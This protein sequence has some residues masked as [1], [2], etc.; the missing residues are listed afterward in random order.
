MSGGSAVSRP[1]RK[2]IRTLYESQFLFRK[3][4]SLF[5]KQINGVSDGLEFCQLLTQTLFEFLSFSVD[6]FAI[7]GGQSPKP[8]G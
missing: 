2:L 8:A 1:Y 6:W 5:A 7:L 4:A 3:L